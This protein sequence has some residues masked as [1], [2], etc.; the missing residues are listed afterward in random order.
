MAISVQENRLRTVITRVHGFSAKRAMTT[1]HVTRLKNAA[2]F[3]RVRISRK[4]YV[5]PLPSSSLS[6]PPIPNY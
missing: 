5:R 2:K 4:F 1:R 3:N 6:T